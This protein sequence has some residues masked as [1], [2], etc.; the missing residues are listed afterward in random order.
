MDYRT[1][2]TTYIY[3]VINPSYTFIPP[4]IPKTYNVGPS[5]L[6]T[7]L[8]GSQYEIEDPFPSL[9]SAYWKNTDI[10]W[11]PEDKVTWDELAPSLQELIIRKIKWE[12][13]HITLQKR[14]TELEQYALDTRQESREN[15]A[16]HDTWLM[17]HD[18]ILHE[19]ELWLIRIDKDIADLDRRVS[20]IE[21]LNGTL[22]T[23]ANGQV[24]KVS[25]DGNLFADDNFHILKFGTDQT[26]ITQMEAIPLIT[27]RDVFNTWD[28]FTVSWYDGR[29]GYI[30]E[31]G[32]LYANRAWTLT[33]YGGV[34]TIWTNGNWNCSSY[35][36]SHRKYD[37]YWVKIR[38]VPKA[39]DHDDDF[40]G[41]VISAWK[42][43]S[44][45]IHTLSAIIDGLAD[46]QYSG[47]AYG[48]D[49]HTG[50]YLN[51]TARLVYNFRVPESLSQYQL[52]LASTN[53]SL[54]IV[55][56]VETG[57]AEGG[58]TENYHDT[59]GYQ[60]LYA[61]RNGNQVILKA[62]EYQNRGGKFNKYETTLTFKLPSTQPS[63]AN[64]T[65]WYALQQ[66]LSEPAAMGFMSDSNDGG[67]QLIDQA[68]LFAESSSIYNIN[69]GEVFVYI[70]N[71]WRPVGNLFEDKTTSNLDPIYTDIIP[72][73][74]WLY[75]PYNQRL[76]WYQEPGVYYEVILKD[77]T[78]NDL[79][80][81]VFPNGAEMWVE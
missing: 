80:H 15:D 81:L 66:M 49:S 26:T 16:D 25:K 68:K 29:P 20:I 43:S 55:S 28:R 2:N 64:N 74:V 21:M 13:L 57:T 36:V 58:I 19:H 30:N 18:N 41:V 60:Y 31:P 38:L 11:D 1:T 79:G 6:Y 61:E 5:Y 77:R 3:Q 56:A 12:D 47:G 73:R 40:L 42:D 54:G 33:N 76:Y 65:Q 63:W 70:D 69:T 34:P 4:T 37:N 7:R 51:G 10:N 27:L 9:T 24:V 22:A 45:Y 71:V 35:F 52:T 75:N 39:G 23:G 46:Q 59:G 78:F 50:V 72:H 44:G 53:K 8:D 48:K 32:D 17:D 67:F 14:W 62:T